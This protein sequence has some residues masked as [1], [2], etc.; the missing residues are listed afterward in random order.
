MRTKT[1]PSLKWL[2]DRRGRLLHKAKQ[3]EKQAKQKRQRAADHDTEKDQVQ[4]DIAAIDRVLSLHE[5]RIDPVTLGQKGTQT[6]GR[7]FPWNHLT[8]NILACLRSAKGEWCSTTHIMA[9]VAARASLEVTDDVYAQLRLSIRNRMQN[10][11]RTG[12]V[13]RRHAAQTSYE[14]YWALP[15]RSTT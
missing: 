13:I 2:V 14:G 10:L 1:P 6:S 11:Y 9:F 7:L 3:L 12:R 4:R 15:K 8:R 5:I